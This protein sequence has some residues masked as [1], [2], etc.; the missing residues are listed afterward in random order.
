MYQFLFINEEPMPKICYV[1]NYFKKPLLYSK[2][3]AFLKKSA[4][5]TP[6]VL[7]VYQLFCRFAI[8]LTTVLKL[9]QLKLPWCDVIHKKIQNFHFVVLHLRKDSKRPLITF[10]SVAFLNKVHGVILIC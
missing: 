10:K 5:E 3:F 9:P 8:D 7:W 2:E 4:V 6:S 1:P